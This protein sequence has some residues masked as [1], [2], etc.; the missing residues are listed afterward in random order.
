MQGLAQAST[1]VV[2]GF[3][4]IGS[5]GLIFGDLGGRLFGVEQFLG[6]L[7]RALQSTKLTWGAMRRYGSERWGFARVMTVASLVN[8]VTLQIPFLM[9]PAAFDLASSGQ[10]FLAYRVL[11]LPAS[12]VGSAVSQVFFGE[13]SFRRD[14]SRRLHD[15]ALDAAVSLFV[16]SIPTYAIVAAGGPALIQAVFGSQWEQAGLYARILAPSLALWAVASPISALLLVGRREVESL[17]FTA[18][19]LGLRFGALTIGAALHSLTIGIVIL[20]VADVAINIGALWRFLRVASVHL[21]DLVRPT[22]RIL[23][24]TIPGACLVIVCGTAAPVIV[25]LAAGIGW[26]VSF[27]LAARLSPEFR[28]LVSGSHD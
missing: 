15:L 9:I 25:I 18:G 22:A 27:G 3:A 8:A 14:D 4:G 28:A 5:A 7:R 20:S 11:V 10:Y 21:S 24:L 1:Q 17:A 26:I 6:P 2:L 23:A 12:L 19:E 16:F 13:A